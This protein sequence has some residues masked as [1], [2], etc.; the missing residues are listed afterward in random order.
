MK[1][2]QQKVWKAMNSTERYRLL[3]VQCKMRL[4]DSARFFFLLKQKLNRWLLLQNW[5]SLNLN[6]FQQ[7]LL[8]RMILSA[9]WLLIYHKYGIKLTL[10]L[11]RTLKFLSSLRQWILKM[12]KSIINCMTRSR[13]SKINQRASLKDWEILRTWMIFYKRYRMIFIHF[14]LIKKRTFLTEEKYMKFPAIF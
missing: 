13:L 4:P 14:K 5:I 7:L 2:L 8:L 11:S 12:L 9:R 6:W 3:T 1:S 10:C